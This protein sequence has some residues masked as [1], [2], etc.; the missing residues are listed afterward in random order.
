MPLARAPTALRLAAAA[1]PLHRACAR[2]FHATTRA[3]V[4]VG[5]RLPDV[6]LMETSPGN[7]VNLARELAHGKA[8]IIGVPAAFSLF[9]PTL[10]PAR[11]ERE[12]TELCPM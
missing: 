5:D 8:L 10:R 1:R 7:K 6:D 11:V 4:S 2:S 12:L 3:Q 9:P